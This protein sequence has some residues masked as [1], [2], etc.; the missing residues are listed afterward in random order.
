MDLLFYL[1]NGY[2]PSNL[3]YKNKHALRLKAK[4]FKIID[5][6]LF[7]RNYDSVLLRCLKKPEA[8]EVLQELHD[9]PTG[10][11]FGRVTIVHKIIHTSYYWPTLFKDAHEYVRKC[12]T[13]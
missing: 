1:K 11:H 3:S 6:V 8:Q 10:G 5:D 7:R 13:Y 4:H 12:R 9:G 2:A